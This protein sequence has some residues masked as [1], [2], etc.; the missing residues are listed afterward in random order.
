[1]SMVL[2]SYNELEEELKEINNL[3][4]PVNN[5]IDTQK[6]IDEL[7]RNYIGDFNTYN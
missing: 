6:E 7:L 5:Y 1:M 2:D 4:L 3:L